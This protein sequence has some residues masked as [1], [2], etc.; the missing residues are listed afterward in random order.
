[1]RRR[2]EEQVT[3]GERRQMPIDDGVYLF[4]ARR[5]KE[6][7][8]ADLMRQRGKPTG[9]RFAFE[10]QPGKQPQVSKRPRQRL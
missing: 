10:P 4:R 1:M 8:Q 9:G 6:G 3:K 2:W 7:D 5:S